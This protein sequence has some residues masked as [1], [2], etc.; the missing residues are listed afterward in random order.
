MTARRPPGPAVAD[1][2]GYCV[3]V[4]VCVPALF[5]IPRWLRFE[6]NNVA[7]LEFPVVFFFMPIRGFL[8]LLDQLQQ[9][10]VPGALAGTLQGLL[11]CAWRS[12]RVDAKTHLQRVALGAIT[13]A[14]VGSMI[15]GL[16]YVPLVTQSDAPTTLQIAIDVTGGLVCGLFSAIPALALLESSPTHAP[17]ELAGHATS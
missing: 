3:L 9:G 15:A 2:V 8:I 1:A 13:G 4:F 16:R 17:A 12:I 5:A 6:L 11:L 7:N 10:A 14:L